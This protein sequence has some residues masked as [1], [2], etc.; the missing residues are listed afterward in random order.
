MYLKAIELHGFKSFPDKTK[1][2]FEK[3]M[4][5]ISF[6]HAAWFDKII[7]NNVEV[8]N[9][10]G[11]PLIK[12]WSEGGEIISGNFVCDGGSTQLRDLAKED[13]VCKAI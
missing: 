7:L 10:T 3:G 13:F 8:K 2:E 6:I 12:T 1:I 4:D 9:V 5:D 11:T